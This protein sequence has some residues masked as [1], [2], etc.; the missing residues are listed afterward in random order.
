MLFKVEYAWKN[1]LVI[2][3]S[4]T[5]VECVWKS[6][7]TKKKGQKIEPKRISELPISKP[8]Y[9]KKKTVINSKE[10]QDFLPLSD[11]SHDK[12]S[13]KNIMSSLYPS[14]PNACGFRYV[15]FTNQPNFTPDDDINVEHT[16]EV[17]TSPSVP[18]S[19]LDMLFTADTEEDIM[20]ML[21]NI[22]KDEVAALEKYTQGQSNNVLWKNQRFGRITA[23]VSHRVMTKV[24]TLTSAKSTVN[25]TSLLSTLCPDNKVCEIKNSA[26][27]YG[28]HMEDEARRVYVEQL[29]MQ[30]HKNVRVSPCGLFVLPNMAY[31]GASPDGLV[32][33][34]CCGNGC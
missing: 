17:Q 30:K 24:N 32:D 19:I 7:G 16:V 29:K 25:C 23:S 1:G 8:Q 28:I 6:Y 31:I 33:C 13:H 21:C 14:L 12:P 2:K 11:S 20:T 10:K 18:K 15:S 4:P 34:D 27:L 22:N 5:S 3:D 9:K 26:L